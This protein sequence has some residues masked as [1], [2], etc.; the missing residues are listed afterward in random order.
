M[1]IN[2]IIVNNIGS[3]EGE[4]IFDILEQSEEGKIVL[5]GGKNGAGKTTLF[6]AIKL[7][8]Y[9]Y[10]EG[11]Y[12]SINTFYK[13]KVKKLINNN[14]K[15][16]DGSKAY[17]DVEFSIISGTDCIIYKVN[18]SW[19]IIGNDIEEE[20]DVYKDG[21]I[22]DEDEKNDFENY[23]LN[24]IPPDLFDLYFFDG[25][26]IT[27]YFLEEGGDLRLKNAFMLLCGYDTFDIMY[28]NFKR[29]NNSN[30][31]DKAVVNRYT[32][33]K[34]KYEEAAALVKKV[35]NNVVEKKSE[36][37]EMRSLLASIEREYRKKGGVTLKEWNEKFL[38]LKEEECLRETKND[39]IKKAANESLPFLIIKDRIVE[40]KK[41][42]EDE[43]TYHNSSVMRNMCET[44][45]HAI[46]DSARNSELINDDA[47]Q[48]MLGETQKWLSQ[49]GVEKELLLGLSME[50][51]QQLSMLMAHLLALS[52]EEI[53]DN[54][55]EVRESIER[56]ATLRSE[57]DNCS[58]GNFQE[59]LNEKEELLANIERLSKELESLVAYKNEIEIDCNILLDRFRKEE[60]LLDDELKKSSVSDL[61]SRAILF[62]DE[63]QRKLFCAE[64]RKVESL[65]LSQID[66]MARKNNFID[67]ITI[68]EE[69]GVHIF[70][71]ASVKAS[72]IA[73]KYISLGKD[74][75][76]K[77]YGIYH[78]ESLMSQIKNEEDLLI[79]LNG[80]NLID[81]VYEI[82]KTLLS[83]GEQ[84]IF[85]MT[86]YWSIMQ[87]CKQTVPFFID[88]PF[89][90]IDTEHRENITEKFFKKLN[91][92]VFIFST[93]EEIVG[94]HV[95]LLGDSIQACFMLENVDNK[96]TNLI[97]NK[98]FGEENGI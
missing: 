74:G 90:R 87:L 9:G 42:I 36:L 76:I 81:V 20:L 59:Y 1:K 30:K 19:H 85:I 2:R 32:A 4:N 15:R 57:I 21:I 78:W 86:L 54:R 25:E 95:E 5:I 49:Y 92:Q 13:K 14:A 16:L 56:G 61:S 80:H 12:Q 51:K 53:L 67:G 31:T 34:D 24:I 69:F 84:Q 33:A 50:E 65:F 26:K 22:L 55:R 3:Y 60:K 82:D 37:V 18:R 10:K 75:Y 79:R 41:Q 52:D 8:L 93:N 39:W 43:D 97:A 72:E 94:K 28:K 62:L 23:I 7:C 98:Y 89:A 91:G 48:F 29:V 38:Q 17:I 47:V 88:T 73:A 83:K 96:K 63:L 35:S 71:K 77:E 40:L 68:D 45:I 11:G 64:L 66:K 44:T 6:N 58:I 27:G 70:R 46:L